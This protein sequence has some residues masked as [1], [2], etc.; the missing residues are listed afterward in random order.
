[1]PEDKKEPEVSNVNDIVRQR[2]EDD[3]KS[4]VE[5]LLKRESEKG[6]VRDKEDLSRPIT[7]GEAR[8]LV[9]TINGSFD[10]VQEW[11]NGINS[12]IDNRDRYMVDIERKNELLV[13]KIEELEKQILAMKPIPL[14]KTDLKK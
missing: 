10:K 12:I 5:A 8:K 7:L 11:I 1:M 2:L 14:P 3:A 6:I 4:S 9:A 13:Q